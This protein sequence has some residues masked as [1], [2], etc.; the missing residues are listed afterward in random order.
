MHDTVSVFDANM[1]KNDEKNHGNLD[2]LRNEMMEKMREQRNELM[3]LLKKLD[4]KSD[5]GNDEDR[6][7]IDTLEEAIMKIEHLLGDKAD[8]GTVK[9]LLSFLENKINYLF[10]LV[11]GANEEDALIGRKNWFCMSCDK[12]LDKYQGKV[13]PHLPT[14]QLKSKNLDQETVGGGMTL[15]PS[16]SK[17]DLPHVKSTIQVKKA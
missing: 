11:G 17:V 7:R 16:K 2:D 3:R 10:T 14:S 8:I 5:D 9:K 15:R 6:R 4:M 12:K 1:K 13:G